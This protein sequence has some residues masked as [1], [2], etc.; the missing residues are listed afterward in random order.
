MILIVEDEALVS[1]MVSLNLEHAGF[2]V[3]ACTTA[4]AA[5]EHVHQAE[6]IILDRMLPGMD[7]LAFA[8]HLRAA[9]VTTPIL[10][11]TARG[12]VAA[13]VAGLDAG[14]DDY[15]AKPFAMPELLARVRALRR[16]ALDA[17][18]RAPQ[19]NPAAGSTTRT[20]RFDKYTVNLN[21]REALTNDG[22]EVLTETECQL[23][24]YFHDHAG[25]MLSRADILESVW[26]MDKFPTAR[27][28]DNYVLRLRKLF[29]PD[30]ENPR[31]LIT[32]RGRGYVFR[33]DSPA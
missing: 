4:E 11:L 9:S 26:G 1:D 13:R 19:P 3:Q 8:R 6:L 33:P 31:Y 2:D 15:L 21:T 24:V 29:E 28:V 5:L 32:V 12:E 18:P 7:G 17:A 23:L 20:L 14:A 30:P 16:R 22:V 25:D 27:T 10:M